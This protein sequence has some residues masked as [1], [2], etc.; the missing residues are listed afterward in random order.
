[1][2]QLKERQECQKEN[3]GL[4]LIKLIVAMAVSVIVLSASAAG[5]MAGVHHADFVRNENYAETIYYA[6]QAELMKYRGDGKLKKLE[7]YVKKKEQVVPVNEISDD[8]RATLT[9]E[10]ELTAYNAK[11]DGRLYYLK[12]N[13]GSVGEN[14]KLG[15]LLSPYIYD[16]SI[17]DGAICIEFDPSVGTVYSVTYSDRNKEF[18]YEIPGAV[19]GAASLLDRRGAVRRKYRVGYYSA[20]LLEA[21]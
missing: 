10:G 8:Y 6:A 19:D 13:A 1:M 3:M 7:E 15:E 20:E 5:I 4:T 18:V 2:R 21:L 16:T 12:K 9:G 17:M 11:Y 14:D